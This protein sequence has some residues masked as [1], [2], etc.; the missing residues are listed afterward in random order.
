MKTNSSSL[1]AHAI[2]GVLVEEFVANGLSAAQ[3]AE[4]YGVS[5]VLVIDYIAAYLENSPV[6]LKLQT[7]NS[8]STLHEYLKPI[9]RNYL[10]AVIKTNTTIAMAAKYAGFSRAR[11]YDLLNEHN[12]NTKHLRRFDKNSDLRGEKM[13]VHPKRKSRANRQSRAV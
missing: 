12:I 8:S 10:V 7:S 2:R 3:I 11:F 6:I 9:V 4:K 13:D 5:L 1:D